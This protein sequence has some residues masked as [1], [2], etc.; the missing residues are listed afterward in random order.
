LRL[1]LTRT[2][3]GIKLNL[4]FEK[5]KLYNHLGELFRLFKKHEVFVG[6]G[7][8][9]SLFNGKEF[10]DIDI[11]FRSDKHLAA[12][13]E[14]TFNGSGGW[15]ICHTRKA[16]LVRMKDKEVQMIHFRYFDTAQELF[17]TFD[18]T[19][20]MGAYDFKTEE[21]F[22]HEDFMKHNSQ[23]I[24]KFNGGTAYPMVSLIRVQKYNDKGYSISKSELLR[25]S[26]ACMALEI[27]SYDDL[28]E[29]LGGMYGANFDNLF[30]DVKD[31]E[32]DLVT[33]SEKIAD[34]V[35]S[36]DYFKVP[37]NPIE[38]DSPED[39]IDSIMQ[40]EIEYFQHGNEYY[41]I[42]LNGDIIRV[43][44]SKLDIF[45][46][47]V[48]K[49]VVFPSNWKKIEANEYFDRTKFYKFVK[50]V[51]DKLFSYYDKHF[52]YKIGEEVIGLNN[53]YF[54]HLNDLGNSTYSDQKD[55]VCLE[56]SIKAEDY[57]T[58]YSHVMAKKCTVLRIVPKEEYETWL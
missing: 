3:G 24:L 41:K 57:R 48:S 17:D 23:R 38:F 22:F 53:L 16:T 45:G 6:G 27:S 50:P 31:E 34:I 13:I 52:E 37:A 9:T 8:I 29:H 20:C 14:D 58:S 4:T 43:R 54:S 19:V 21:F 7:T 42:H 28:K 18:F 32:F 5:N 2:I 44:D 35:Y 40:S 25:I 1:A 11:Y 49:S 39:L 47:G 33:A 15:V 55:K 56:V 51:G 46:I 30:K 12:F 36:E 10:N 26:M